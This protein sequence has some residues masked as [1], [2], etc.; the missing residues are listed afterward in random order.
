MFSFVQ[1]H[2]NIYN[3]AFWELETNT[4]WPKKYSKNMWKWLMWVLSQL[5]SYHII[6]IS[7]LKASTGS[8]NVKQSISQRQKLSNPW[9]NESKKLPSKVKGAVKGKH[10]LSECSLAA[11]CVLH[12]CCFLQ[13]VTK[14]CYLVGGFNPSGKKYKS[15]W[16]SSPSRGEH[17]K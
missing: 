17:K 11:V 10:L 15:N 5:N 1:I 14:Q 8:G 4:Y 3:T 2:I 7:P 6:S 13:S 16:Q 12:V 9:S